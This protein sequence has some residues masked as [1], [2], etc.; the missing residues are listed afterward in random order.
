VLFPVL[1]GG[2][3]GLL[4]FS[5]FLSWL[6]GRFKDQTIAVLTGFILGSLSILW[7]W[8]KTI[9]LAN[10]TGEQILRNNLPVVER[11]QPILPESFDI[12]VI[13]AA[14][15]MIAGILSLWAI[16]SSGAIRNNKSPDR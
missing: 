6:L 12:I 15:L 5:H 7:P 10:D 11:Y 13:F 2:G 8:K 9:W 1:L 16:E 3:L 14:L 4:A